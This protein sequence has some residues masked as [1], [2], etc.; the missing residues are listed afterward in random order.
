[1][2]NLTPE[3]EIWLQNTLNQFSTAQKVGQLFF[4][5]TFINATEGHLQHITKLIEQEKI[6]GLCFFHSE[7]SAA[8]NF[9]KKREVV[10]NEASVLQ[11]IE[12]INY[13]QSLA[14]I[15][16]LI[17]IDAEWGLAMRIEETP[18][19]PYA[20]TLGAV[21]DLTLVYEVG[22]K[23][24]EHCKRVGVHLNFAPVLDVN[25]NADNPVIGYRAFGEN[26]QQVSQKAITYLQ[27]MQAG[28]ILTCGKHFPGHGD[29][30]ID[31]HLAL[32]LIEKNLT[33]LK[34]NELLTFQ[35]AFEAGLDT[36]MSGHIALPNCVENPHEE[37]AASLS[38]TLLKKL[39]KAQ[40]GFEGLVLTDALN[41][42]SVSQI[43][44]QKGVLELKALQAGNDV[45]L[46]SEEVE[47]AYEY[48]MT[49]L[50]Q[51]ELTETEIN[52]K[53][54]KILQAKAFLQIDNTQRINP[55]HI[56]ED[57]FGLEQ[58]LIQ[59]QVAE[60]AFTL[61]KTDA[62]LLADIQQHKDSFAFLQI[63]PPAKSILARDVVNHLGI[64]TFAFSPK[65]EQ[66]DFSALLQALEKYPNL[67][68][69][70]YPKQMKPLDNFGIYQNTRKLVKHLLEKHQIGCYYF[71]NPYS[72][73][74]F[75]GLE[76][77]ALLGMC[78]QFSTYLERAAL[79]HL[80][81]KLI[82]EGKLP[83]G[84]SGKFQAGFG[85]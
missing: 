31:S 35:A 11:L 28:G 48:I 34:N 4:A 3:R 29:T 53:V 71:G 83:V 82:S 61:L 5:A 27:G 69:A 55:E 75:E 79:L 64:Q 40:M 52:T 45:L 70:I 57:L 38:S 84:I 46:Y 73:R 30:N 50:N 14:K 7:A 72:L 20:M 80:E 9:E 37:H 66:E 22:K 18:Q 17:C 10:Y 43:F 51:N 42:K 65:N 21:Q 67:I 16:L 76:N 19:F 60:A 41:M 58:E 85:L 54:R 24:G 74:L 81:G 12:H 62:L 1:M 23:I 32:P 44:P 49:A 56:K 63:D 8:A 78:Y 15:P 26:P 33:D 77:A 68:L 59:T 39:L 13:Y 36:L 2:Q 25:T 47:A 6:G